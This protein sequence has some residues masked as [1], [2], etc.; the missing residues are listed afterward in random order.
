MPTVSTQGLTR[1]DLLKHTALA[2]GG[3]VLGFLVPAGRRPAFAQAPEATPA[4][5]APNAFLRIGT[6]DSVTVLLSHSEMGQGIWTSLP[7]LVAEELDAD[8]SKF[9]VEHAPAADVYRHVIMKMQMTG[10][11]TSTWSEFDRYRQVGAAARMMLLQAAAARFGVPVADCRTG[12]GV[13]I[14]C[15]PRKL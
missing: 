8:W 11:S 4:L 14:G 2:G 15:A 12:G 7:M 3:L 9:R 6:D 1:R 13:V 5:P 10:G